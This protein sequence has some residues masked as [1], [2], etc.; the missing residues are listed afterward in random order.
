MNHNK[1]LRA[2]MEQLEGKNAL[3]ATWEIQ[4]QDLQVK[5]APYLRQLRGRIRTIRT[6]I[7]HRRDAEANDAI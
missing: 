7:L 6:Y 4:P 1:A 5:E 3:L 2:L